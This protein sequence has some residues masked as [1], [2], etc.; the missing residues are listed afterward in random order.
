MIFDPS[1]PVMKVE[2]PVT[3]RLPLS[4]ILP[5]VAMA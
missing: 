1:A 3:T 2:V 5:V 4:D